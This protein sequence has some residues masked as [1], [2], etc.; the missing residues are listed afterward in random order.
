MGRAAIVAEDYVLRD[1]QAAIIK[2]KIDMII[3]YKAIDYL[4][5][6]AE[7]ISLGASREDTFHGLSEGY[8]FVLSLQFTDYFTNSEVNS[9]LEQMMEGDGFWDIT[10][11]ELNS[12]VDQIE[13][14]TNCCDS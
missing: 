14:A 12:M 5:G 7:S 3:A 13:S 2:Q 9:M 1:E 4:S 11:D 8:G 6:G 10:V